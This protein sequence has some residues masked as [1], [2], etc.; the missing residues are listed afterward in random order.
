MKR[1]VICLA[2]F[3]ALIAEAATYSRMEV[4]VSSLPK[5]RAFFRE[6]VLSRVWN[7][8]PPSDAA[9]TLTV[10]FVTDASFAGENAA[11]KVAGGVAGNAV[12]EFAARTAAFFAGGIFGADRAGAGIGKA[13]EIF[14]AV[15]ETV[16]HRKSAPFA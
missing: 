2:A 15:G 10:R 1:I 16:V 13:V 8:T 9:G 6:V 11:V 5:E 3:V 12:F 4:E 14:D 7:R